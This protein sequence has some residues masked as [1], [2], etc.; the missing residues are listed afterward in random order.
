MLLH[1]L[2]HLPDFEVDFIT[3]ATR[4]IL[5][6][7]FE[8]LP[9]SVISQRFMIL[10]PYNGTRPYKQCMSSFIKTANSKIK[11]KGERIRD[12]QAWK[13]KS[14][15]SKH[16]PKHFGT[17]TNSSQAMLC[18]HHLHDHQHKTTVPPGFKL[19][20]KCIKQVENNLGISKCLKTLVA[21]CKNLSVRSFKAIRMSMEMMENLIYQEPGVKIIHLV[22]DPRGIVSS[23]FSTGQ[24][25]VMSKHVK[26]K[27]AKAL[28]HRMLFDLEIYTKLRTKYPQNIVQVKYE[29]IAQSPQEQAGFLYKFTRG[30]PLPEDVTSFIRRSTNATKDNGNFGTSRVDPTVTAN[31][32]KTKLSEASKMNILDSCRAVIEKLGYEL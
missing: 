1:F 4:K 12:E 25:S 11:D 28:C 24:I 22:R 21:S 5:N 15:I 20:D 23:R 7:D 31:R 9:A 18:Y 19:H 30:I 16:C 29:E 6:C 26:Q 13:C 14:Y 17:S 8:S 32:W 10:R 27:E 2:R 3:S